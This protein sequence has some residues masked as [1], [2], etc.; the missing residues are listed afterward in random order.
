MKKSLLFNIVELDVKEFVA[1]WK[2]APYYDINTKISSVS[3]LT[4]KS[5]FARHFRIVLPDFWIEH[6]GRIQDF[7]RGGKTI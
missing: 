7:L 2:A 4:K 1:L 3:K 6:K 5:P